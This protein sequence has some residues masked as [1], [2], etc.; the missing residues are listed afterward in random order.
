MPSP[1]SEFKT[2]ILAPT[3]KAVEIPSVFAPF[4]NPIPLVLSRSKQWHAV[5]VNLHSFLA[6]HRNLTIS[7]QEQYHLRTT[8]EM[9]LETRIINSVDCVP[10]TGVRK[11][12]EKVTQSIIPLG[13]KFE[14]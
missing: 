12:I 8:E 4:N 7:L 5:L 9:C 11:T 13:Q 1:K 14:F 2:R 3:K 10:A 6:H